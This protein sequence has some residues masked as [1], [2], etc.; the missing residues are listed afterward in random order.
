[1]KRLASEL[2]PD[3]EPALSK[4]HLHSLDH[5]DFCPPVFFAVNRCASSAWVDQC[6][7][8]D[9]ELFSGLLEYV[10]CSKA[11]Q[12]RF[13]G[14]CVC[15]PGKSELCEKEYFHILVRRYAARRAYFP[16][17]L[18]PSYVR[19][20]SGPS[21]PPFRSLFLL[22]FMHQRGF[23]GPAYREFLIDRLY[24]NNRNNLASH[25]VTCLSGTLHA[26]WDHWQAC[27][28]DITGGENSLARR[29]CEFLF[30]LCRRTEAH[31]F[32]EVLNMA[33]ERHI[34]ELYILRVIR[35]LLSG[36]LHRRSR[37]SL[38]QWTLR[39]GFSPNSMLLL[40]ELFARTPALSQSPVPMR[41]PRTLR[42]PASPLTLAGMTT[43]LSQ[44][45]FQFIWPVVREGVGEFQ[46]KSTGL[47]GLKQLVRWLIESGVTGQTRV[48]YLRD[49]FQAFD[50][51]I[52]RTGHV[53]PEAVLEAVSLETMSEQLWAV[54]LNP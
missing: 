25:V 8:P 14:R 29:K 51:C 46:F 9:V 45:D 3:T 35:T 2:I 17:C 36:D 52:H 49:I 24:D 34:P 15:V 28:F 20:G 50:L 10:T 27:R 42:P 6:G 40:N 47:E 37:H 12:A 13:I 54:R 30:L 18:N 19:Q 38:L 31:R 48:R 16:Y 23:Y 7:Y 22:D 32:F 39:C 5:P 33:Y 26:N 21:H 44:Y 4:G 41:L 53:N 1:M 11:Q 43:I